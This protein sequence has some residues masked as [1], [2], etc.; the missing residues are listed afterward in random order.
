MTEPTQFPSITP[1]FGLP[2]LYAGQAQKEFFVN[3]ALALTDA[4]LG[5][6]IEGETVAPP[7]SPIDGTAWL[8]ATGG[9]GEWAGQDAALACRQGGNWLFVQPRDGVRILDRTTG[10]TRIFLGSWQ[11][12]SAPAEPSGG[13]VVDAEARAAI[14]QLLAVLRLATVLPS[15]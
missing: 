14:V 13:S 1:R 10:Q 3:E 11:I 8:V 5:C 4:L 2:L 15:S 7:P 9:T 12:P 6:V